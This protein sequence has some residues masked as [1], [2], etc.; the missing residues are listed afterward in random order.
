[1]Q[2]NYF[3]YYRIRDDLDPDDAHASVRSMQSALERRTGVRGRLFTRFHEDAT[4][5]EVYEG[6]DAPESFEQALRDELQRHRLDELIQPGS[7]RHLE[8]FIECV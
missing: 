3:I 5:M 2:K 6:V 1:M 4:W 8:C 7:A